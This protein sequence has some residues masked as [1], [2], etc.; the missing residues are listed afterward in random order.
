MLCPEETEF[1]FTM[2]SRGCTKG[3]GHVGCVLTFPISADIPHQ[4]YQAIAVKTAGKGKSR[5]SRQR[6]QRL[7]TARTG[8]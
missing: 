3:I 8:D 1:R 5:Q 6:A 7:R 4:S 2:R